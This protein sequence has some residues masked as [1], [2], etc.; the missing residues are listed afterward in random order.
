MLS[1]ETGRTRPALEALSAQPGATPRDHLRC[2][3]TPAADLGLAAPGVA[4]GGIRDAM[5]AHPVLVNRPIVVGPRGSPSPPSGCSTPRPA[6]VNKELC[7]LLQDRLPEP[8]RY[9]RPS[10]SHAPMESSAASVRNNHDGSTGFTRM[11]AVR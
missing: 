9:R 8:D 7:T 3:E 5:V 1:F 2:K 4:E 11:S 6:G 10:R